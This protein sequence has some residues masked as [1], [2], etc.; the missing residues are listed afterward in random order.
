MINILLY[1]LLC[2]ENTSNIVLPVNGENTY[3]PYS[4]VKI[5]NS[6]TTSEAGLESWNKLKNEMMHIYP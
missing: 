6:F 5:M 4:K 2:Y 1:P 3:V